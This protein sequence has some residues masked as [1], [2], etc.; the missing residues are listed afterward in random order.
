VAAYVV[1]AVIVPSTL[2]NM[3]IGRLEAHMFIFYFAILSA[4]T[5][6][7]ATGAYTA[8]GIARCDPMATGFCAMRLGLVAFLLPYAFT[9]RPG[10]L[11]HGI[12]WEIARA[13]AF[14]TLGI[15][16]WAAATEKYLFREISFTAQLLLGLS[17]IMLIVPEYWTSILGL[18][19]TLLTFII[20]YLQHKKLLSQGKSE[21]VVA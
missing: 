1:L 20:L 2:T 9:Y 10:L 18:L 11:L 6:P 21:K 5:P 12:P 4:I 17:G 7:V 8:A 15:V 16:A 19:V 13:I 14:T 3:G